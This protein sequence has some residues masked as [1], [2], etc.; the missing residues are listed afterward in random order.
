M[1][2][3][4][5]YC[6]VRDAIR[7]LSES[8]L[9]GCPCVERRNDRRDH[10]LGNV[11][12]WRE[13][14]ADRGAI[15]NPSNG[16]VASAFARVFLDRDAALPANLQSQTGSITVSPGGQIAALSD[17]ITFTE[18]GD[19]YFG[20]QTWTSVGSVDMI[21]DTSGFSEALN[22]TITSQ[23]A[24]TV[25][26]ALA[27]FANL[28]GIIGSNPDTTDLQG[29]Y[30]QGIKSVA[31]FRGPFS[32]QVKIGFG[33]SIYIDLCDYYSAIHP[34]S[35]ITEEG[36]DGWITVWIDGNIGLE[37]GI[38]PLGFGILQMPFSANLPDQKDSW[39]FSYLGPISHF[40]AQLSFL[41]VQVELMLG[42]ST[43][44]LILN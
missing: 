31:Y 2:I 19:Y 33:V 25:L 34:D 32:R 37:L 21:T 38:T 30:N 22:I 9:C 24:P 44:P 20:A 26:G 6:A 14:S 43:H 36:R 11:A 28:K 3:R 10:C 35:Y 16:T 17:P 5:Y 39:D 12:N 42:V 1:G 8:P 27:E 15:N 18:T 13:A 23:Y 41:G 7:V 4:E 40:S 29:Q